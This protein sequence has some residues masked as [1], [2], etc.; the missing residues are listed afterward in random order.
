MPAHAQ[1]SPPPFTNPWV[2][3]AR[4]GAHPR[5]VH[6]GYEYVQTLLVFNSERAL[7]RFVE[8]EFHLVANMSMMIGSDLPRWG[9]TAAVH[10]LAGARRQAPA[11]VCPAQT[12]A[13]GGPPP[14]GRRGQVSSGAGLLGRRGRHGECFGAGWVGCCCSPGL[15]RCP[16]SC[17]HAMR[18][19]HA[20]LAVSCSGVDIR[21]QRHEPEAVWAHVAV[22]HHS[23]QPRAGK[24]H[25]SNIRSACCMLR[26]AVA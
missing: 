15:A 14:E 11:V 19:R 23:G 25:C 3:A 10:M 13:P 12:Q 16:P 8:G 17:L 6:A 22:W 4:S 21:P 2:P 7:Q 20:W 1:T 5:G 9:A 26:S 24:P 18:T